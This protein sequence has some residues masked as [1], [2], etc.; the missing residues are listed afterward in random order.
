MSM[1]NTGEILELLESWRNR[2]HP[3]GLNA[4]A[5][6]RTGPAKKNSWWI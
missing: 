4:A 5:G 3:A 2:I 6:S 1:M